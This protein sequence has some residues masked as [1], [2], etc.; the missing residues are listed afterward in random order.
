MGGRTSSESKDRW[1]RNNYDSVL[2]RIPKG[3]KEEIRE[4]AEQRGESVN[5]LINRL[6]TQ[7]MRK[8]PGD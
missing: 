6:L 7:E 2:I 1:N 3:M 5:G 4:Y 8:G